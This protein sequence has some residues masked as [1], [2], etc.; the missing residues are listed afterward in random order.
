MKNLCIGDN[1][2]I[3]CYKHNG[4]VHRIWDEAVILDVKKDY[5]VCGN[6]RTLVT[7]AEGN[8]WRTKE[9]AIMYYFKNEWFNVIC[10]LKKDGIYYYCNIASPFIIEDKT[11]KYIDYDLDLRVFATGEYKILDRLEYKRHQKLMGYS[12]E[13]SMVIEDALERLISLYKKDAHFFGIAQNKE[14]YKLY[15]QLK[16]EEKK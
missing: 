1:L 7:E 12:K 11:I 4:K 14:Y 9:P 3:H 8:T 15:I 13:L 16:N 5:V 10:Q 6:N 2:Q